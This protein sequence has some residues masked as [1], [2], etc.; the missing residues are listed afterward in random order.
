MS[1]SSHW[2]DDNKLNIY[3]KMGLLKKTEN[4]IMLG[5]VGWM[6]S[7]KFYV[8]FFL[9]FFFSYHFFFIVQLLAI[10]ESDIPEQRNFK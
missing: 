8:L 4:G 9:P 6:I 10:Q 7:E 2:C 1:F 5:S 3:M